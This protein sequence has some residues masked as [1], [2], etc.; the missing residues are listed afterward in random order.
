MVDQF[1]RMSSL[2]SADPFWV[3]VNAGDC[4][5]VLFIMLIVFQGNIAK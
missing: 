1:N 2:S 3:I 4:F 5:K